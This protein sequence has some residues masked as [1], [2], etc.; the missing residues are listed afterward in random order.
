M[1]ERKWAVL[2]GCHQLQNHL[3]INLLDPMFRL[4]L[5]TMLECWTP[6]ALCLMPMASVSSRLLIRLAWMFI[7]FAPEKL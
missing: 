2:P 4:H 7:L 5:G 6:M 1:V 3:R